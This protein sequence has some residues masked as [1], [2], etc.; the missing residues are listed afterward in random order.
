MG[1]R[2]PKPK[3]TVDSVLK[4]ALDLV[5]EGGLDGLTLGKLARRL[6][7]TAS[8]LYRYF[9][10][11]AAVLEALQRQA[12]RD[13][14]QH[15]RVTLTRWRPPLGEVQHIALRRILVAL[16]GWREFV[17]THPAE[18]RLIDGFLSAPDPVLSTDLAL[19]VEKELTRVFGQ[20][21]DVLEAAVEVGALEPGDAQ[22]RTQVLAAALHGLGH[23]QKRDRFLDKSLQTPALEVVLL[24]GLLIGWGG[25][26]DRV[27]A[28]FAV[29]N[30]PNPTGN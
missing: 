20:I 15:L 22:Q 5:L 8:A 10:S 24:S 9:P 26:P 30:V 13:L 12:I 3:H 16:R 18:H 2:G 23:F 7:T 1:R 6:N 25:Y 17:L 28:A 27:Q 19:S 11:K 14:D 21:A 4:Q 29:E